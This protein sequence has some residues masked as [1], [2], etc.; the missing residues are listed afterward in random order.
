MVLPAAPGLGRERGPLTA[1]EVR[2]LR[3]QGGKSELLPAQA[4]G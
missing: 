2:G 3:P 1:A 4:S